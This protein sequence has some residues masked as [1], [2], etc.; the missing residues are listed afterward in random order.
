MNVSGKIIPLTPQSTATLGGS[1][2]FTPA[3]R[4]AATVNYVGKQVYD[5]DQA[6]SSALRIPDYAT[7]DIKLT[8]ESAGWLLGVAINNLL[9]KKYYS[10]GIR[11]GAG[12]SFNALPARE[13]NF[14]LAAEY[15]FR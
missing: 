7:M 1:F 4:L 14:A 3:T 11:N 13:R 6:N 10:Y 2:R 15:R 5:N 8:H 12:T 9:D